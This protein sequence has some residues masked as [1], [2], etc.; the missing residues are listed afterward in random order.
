MNSFTEFNNGKDADVIIP[1]RKINNKLPVCNFMD[2]IL[3]KIPSDLKILT[4][5]VE[6]EPIFKHIMYDGKSIKYVINDLNSYNEYFGNKIVKSAIHDAIYYNLYNN[7]ELIKTM[8]G[9]KN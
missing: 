5:S 4:Y 6:G 1:Y 7:D 3:R 9:Y 2:N 8:F